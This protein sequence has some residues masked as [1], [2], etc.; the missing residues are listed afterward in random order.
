ME[1]LQLKVY[2]FTTQ[3]LNPISSVVGVDR[4][5][6]NHACMEA[7]VVELIACAGGCTIL[8]IPEDIVGIEYIIGNPFKENTTL[9]KVI[10][11]NKCSPH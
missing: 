6:V 10:I 3:I 7:R 8:T 11:S 2:I 9:T 1:H 5:F 4:F